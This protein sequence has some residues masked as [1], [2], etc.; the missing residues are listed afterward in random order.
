LLARVRD[1]VPVVLRTRFREPI[2]L[3]SAAIGAATTIASV[4]WAWRSLPTSSAIA[5]ACVLGSLT[6]LLLAAASRFDVDVMLTR[7][8]LMV[9]KRAW[10]L[11]DVELVHTHQENESRRHFV[12]DVYDRSRTRYRW[13]LGGT[14][15]RLIESLVA[16]GVTTR[17]EI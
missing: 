16:V 4:A 8:R 5:A 13:H 7:R 6:I 15:E 1:E 11:A 3:V 2:R 14:P 12:L 10:P 17:A 9:G